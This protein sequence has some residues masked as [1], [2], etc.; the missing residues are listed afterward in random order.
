MEG[1]IL[2]GSIVTQ[3]FTFGN[4]T[5]LV[6]SIFHQWVLSFPL[7]WLP[8]C[9]WKQ[10]TLWRQKELLRL[11]HPSAFLPKSRRT[12]D[13]P[14]SKGFPERHKSRLGFLKC[15]TLTPWME[16]ATGTL[17]GTQSPSTLVEKSTPPPWIRWHTTA[18]P[19][20]ARC[21]RDKSP[22]FEIPEDTF[23]LTAMGKYS[24]TS[25]ITCGP[26]PW[27]C[28]TASRRWRC[29]EGRLISFRY[30]LCWR[31]F[32]NMSFRY[33]SVSKEARWEPWSWWML[34]LRCVFFFLVPFIRSLLEVLF[35]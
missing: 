1:F 11:P 15:S 3:I 26:T 22:C 6:P 32:A 29:S 35:W 24:D 9:E 21:L 33:L 30:A 31:R 17:S 4:R 13:S 5:S 7:L 14:Q 20:S 28:R 23:S 34:N 25:W 12:L 2:F 27:T 10:L 8:H 19:C 16:T 18:T